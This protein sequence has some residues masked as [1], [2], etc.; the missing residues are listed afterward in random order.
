MPT[1]KS[2]LAIII[3]DVFIRTDQSSENEEF[4]LRYSF[5]Q[6]KKR[7]NRVAVNELMRNV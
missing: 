4:V 1:V 3:Y 2:E 5:F 7:I 6:L